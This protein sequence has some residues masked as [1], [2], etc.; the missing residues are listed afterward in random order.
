MLHPISVKLH[1]A[2][3]RGKTHQLGVHSI[4]DSISCQPEKL[5]GNCEHGVTDHCG[6]SRFDCTNH[7]YNKILKSDW[8][9]FVMIS[10]LMNK[11]V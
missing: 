2:D 3:L 4:L 5:S 7:N 6:A 8:L 10:A 9:S 1:R 11:T